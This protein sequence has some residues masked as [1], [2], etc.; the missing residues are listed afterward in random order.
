[1]IDRLYNRKYSESVCDL[2]LNQLPSLLLSAVSLLLGILG[3]LLIVSKRQAF[4]LQYAVGLTL[5]DVMFVLVTNN[6]CHLFS[7]NTQLTHRVPLRIHSDL[8]QSP[9]SL[10][11]HSTY[12]ASSSGFLSYVCQFMCVA[13]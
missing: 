6:S 3:G 7:H 13:K 10:M 8:T 1:M 9:L 12:P 2:T 5:M 11:I 4:L